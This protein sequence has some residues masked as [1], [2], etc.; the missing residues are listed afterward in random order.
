MALQLSVCFAERNDALDCSAHVE[1]TNLTGA[2]TCATVC[3]ADCLILRDIRS[4][5]AVI[6]VYDTAGNVIETHDHAGDF[7]EP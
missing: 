5:D 6:R 7:V 2:K 3:V 4:H 1:N